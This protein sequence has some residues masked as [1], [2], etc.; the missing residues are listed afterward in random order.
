MAYAISDM[1]G[2]LL[3]I[4]V[5]IEDDIGDPLL[6]VLE[7]RE[8]VSIDVASIDRLSVGS[9]IIEGG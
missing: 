1:G 7:S 9:V 6:S 5:K 4:A 8:Q 3:S 2:E